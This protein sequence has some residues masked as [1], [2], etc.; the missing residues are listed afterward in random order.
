MA[1]ATQLRNAICSLVAGQSNNGYIRIYQGATKLAEL[2]FGSPAFGS[3]TN[4]V[5]VSNAITAD[6]SADATGV[7]DIFRVFQSDGTTEILNGSCG[8]MASSAQMKMDSVSV[9]QNQTIALT[10]FTYT[11]PS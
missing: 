4:G 10:S 2:R 1:Y 11:A 9:S 7:A 6:T 8:D 5:V 3:P